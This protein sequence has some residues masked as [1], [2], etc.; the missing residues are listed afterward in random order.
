[1]PRRDAQR[2]VV[3]SLRLTYATLNSRSCGVSLRVLCLKQQKLRAPL[4]ARV[5]GLDAFPVSPVPLDATGTP[6]Q[7]SKFVVPPTSPN[8]PLNHLGSNDPPLLLSLGSSKLRAGLDPKLDHSLGQ[9][10]S[11]RSLYPRGCRCLDL[12]AEDLALLFFP[13]HL[14]Q[15]LLPLHPFPL[16]A[17]Q[18]L[19]RHALD[20]G[21]VQ[22]AKLPHDETPQVLSECSQN[23]T[24]GEMLF[25]PICHVGR[26]ST[27]ANASSAGCAWQLRC[28]VARAVSASACG[29]PQSSLQSG[30]G[31]LRTSNFSGADRTLGFHPPGARRPPDGH[32]VLP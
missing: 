2:A 4:E 24:P 22:V 21:L 16:Q 23:T 14:L 3:R 29:A 19:G 26:G 6:L 15:A 32:A 12:I 31:A 9:V 25:G 13:C 27:S 10:S 5:Q 28:A 11:P 17:Q 1:M 7:P 8:P 20:S 18:L 30:G